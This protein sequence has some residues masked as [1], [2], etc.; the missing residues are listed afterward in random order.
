MKVSKL[1]FALALL[2]SVFS[3]CTKED[4]INEPEPITNSSI[5]GEWS[6]TR[7]ECFCPTLETF[8][9][10]NIIWNFKSDGTLEITYNVTLSSDS[11]VP[12]QDNNIQSYTVNNNLI[13]IS[14]LEYDLELNSNELILSDD[15]HLDGPRYFLTK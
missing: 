2:I 15:P 8:D 9:Q 14:N 13:T 7:L 10:E 3:S 12:F 11:N 5:E 6:F 1:F 4:P